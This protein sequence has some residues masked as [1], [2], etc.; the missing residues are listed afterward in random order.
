V[1]DGHAVGHAPGVVR[2]RAER[3]TGKPQEEG[4]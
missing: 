3:H 1:S 2:C 4:E